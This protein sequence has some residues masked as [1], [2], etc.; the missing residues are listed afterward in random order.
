[1]AAITF[2]GKPVT[3]G[4]SLPKP[5]TKA[6]EFRLVDKDLADRHL[7]DWK[8]K[9]K[10]INIVPSLDT[11]VCA[12]SA[13][14]FDAEILKEPEIVVLTVSCDLPFAQDRFCKTEGVSNIIALSQM[15]DKDFGRDYGAEITD[16][17]LEGLLSRAV[18]VAD[19]DGTVVYT[20]QVPE[21]GYEPDY[22][23]ALAAARKALAR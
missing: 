20:Q 15:R 7:S 4:G 13:K 8:G 2:K 18:V 23:A 17:P 3:T 22:E 1:M 14:R 5:G 16:G 10:I 11:S 9:V 21:I 6:P 12:L 19:R